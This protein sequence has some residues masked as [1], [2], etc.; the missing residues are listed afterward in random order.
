MKT[1]TYKLAGTDLTCGDYIDVLDPRTNQAFAKVPALSSSD[2]DLIYEAASKSQVAWSKLS[3]S[4]RAIYLKD[5]SQALLA[6]KEQLASLLVQEVAKPYNDAIT[7]I[8]RTSEYIDYTIEEMYRLENKFATSEQYYGG[9]KSKLALIKHCPHGVVLAIAPFNYPVNL[10]VS[11]IAPALI[12]GNSVVFKPATQ[13]SVVGI[14][15]TELLLAT[16]IP[17]GVINIVT[18]RGRQIGDYLVNNQNAKMISFTGGS[19]TGQ[20]L[21][22]TVTMTPHIL[23]L[24]GKDAAIILDEDQLDLDFIANDIIQGAFSYS[25]QRCTAIKR[26]LVPAHLEKQLIEKLVTIVNSLEVG[27]PEDNAFIVPLIDKKSADF[28]SSLIEDAKNL[29]ATIHTGDKRK[30]NLIYPTL[31]SGVNEQMAIYHDEPFGPVLPIITYQTIDQAIA[32]HNSNK[33]GLQA[34]VYGNDINTLFAISD[35]LQAGTINFNGKTSRGPDNF[36]FIGHKQSGLGVQGVRAALESMTTI[37]T[38]VINLK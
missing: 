14:K 13:G 32:I 28:V 21:S 4:K 6:N 8:V 12:S 26:V 25:A 27:M 37:K 35:E 15:I 7:E 22:K 20:H 3:I 36:P 16:G 18:G 19:Q 34:S 29:N 30:D 33:Y 1:I 9:N 17:T 11:K 10:A 5:W 2:I 38:T 31:I 23:E 24:G